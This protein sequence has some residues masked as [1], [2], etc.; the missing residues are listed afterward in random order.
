MK[1]LCMHE[2]LRDVAVTPTCTEVAHVADNVTD[3]VVGAAV[4]AS[5]AVAARAAVDK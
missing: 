4:L 1:A 2:A 5:P 3:K